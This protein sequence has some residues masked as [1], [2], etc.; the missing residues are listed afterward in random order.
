MAWIAVKVKQTGNSATLNT[1]AISAVIEPPNDENT[2]ACRILL[3][4][5]LGRAV[6]VEGTRETLIKRILAAERSERLERG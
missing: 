2:V 5:N 4:G 1:R 6:T 3:T